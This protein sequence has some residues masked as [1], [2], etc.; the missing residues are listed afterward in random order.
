[1]NAEIETRIEAIVRK[2]AVPVEAIVASGLTA[3]S[4]VGSRSSRSVEV[5]HHVDG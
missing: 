2:L 3:A 5:A 4:Q 1:M